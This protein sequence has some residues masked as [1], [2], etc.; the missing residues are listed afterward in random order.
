M[1]THGEKKG[2]S[3]QEEARAADDAGL[4]Y[5]H[6]PVE[7][8][9]LSDEVVDRFREKAAGLPSPVLVHCPSGKRSGAMVMMHL[10]SEQGMSGKQVIEK[11][12]EIGFECDTPEL[13]AF[14]ES[15][16]ERHNGQ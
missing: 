16:V 15:Y 8:D 13:E 6:H 12:E 2:L 7:G 1:Q 3:P 11:A 14:V 10:A 9:Q 5:L 4:A